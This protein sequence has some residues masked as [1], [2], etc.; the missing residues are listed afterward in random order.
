M[1]VLKTIIFLIIAAQ[2]FVTTVWAESSGASI[3]QIVSTSSS[4]VDRQDKIVEEL[5]VVSGLKTGLQRL[6]EQIASGAKQAP[7]NNNVSGEIRESVVKLVVDSFPKD[8]FVRSATDALK[9]KYDETRYVHLIQMLSTPLA[10]RM[11]ALETAQPTPADI[12]SFVSEVAS[13][14]LPPERIQLMRKL[15]SVTQ[16]SDLFTRMT[17]ASVQVNALV[18]AGDCSEDIKKV[19]K[20]IADVRPEIEKSIRNTVLV[21]YS[22]VYRGVDDA[23]LNEYLKIYEDKDSK[24]VQGI[25]NAAIESEFNDGMAKEVAGL[26]HLI[27]P[28][29]RNQSMFAPK[30]PGEKVVLNNE[31]GSKP[32]RTPPSP[33][34]GR[35]L[36]DCLRFEDSAKV[37]ECTEKLGK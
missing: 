15:D 31:V 19:K 34:S 13:N 36:R 24:W 17:M 6:S 25:V 29:K 35:D 5:L 37:I 7:A 4:G 22:Y 12:K 9:M 27:P 3:N 20:A 11:T 30:C 10:K 23:D 26:K 2:I 16:S 18:V 21:L 8:G 33:K 32:V 1:A 14:P 28:R